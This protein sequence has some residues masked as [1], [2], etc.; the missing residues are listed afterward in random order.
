MLLLTE[1]SSVTDTGP[2]S[3]VDLSS[4]MWYRAGSHSHLYPRG[5]GI[6]SQPTTSGGP[7]VRFAVVSGNL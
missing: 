2:L 4:F 6:K 7:A 3:R 5:I 1:S